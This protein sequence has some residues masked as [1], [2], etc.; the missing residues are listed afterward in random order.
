[1]NINDHLRLPKTFGEALILTT[2]FGELL[3]LRVLTLCPSPTPFRLEAH[4]G[5]LV[6]LPTPG[7]Q[8]R[9]IESLSTQQFAHI[10]RPGRAVRFLQNS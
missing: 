3:G 9:R 8:M 4:Q 10:A 5:T 7:R 2:Q 6:P 1:M